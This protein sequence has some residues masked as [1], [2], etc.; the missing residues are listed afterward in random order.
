MNSRRIREATRPI[1][2]GHR[3]HVGRHD[4]EARDDVPAL[5]AERPDEVPPGEDTAARTR[6]EERDRLAVE[7]AGADNP[8]ERILHDAGDRARILGRGDEHSVCSS[9]LGT[10]AQHRLTRVVSVIGV[11]RGNRREAF[12]RAHFD[13]ARRQRHTGNVERSPVRRSPLKTAADEEDSNHQGRIC[14]DFPRSNTLGMG[15]PGAASPLRRALA[16]HRAPGVWK[17][18]ARGRRSALPVA[19]RS[20]PGWRFA[21]SGRSTQVEVDT[22]TARSVPG[23]ALCI[24]GA[25]RPT[26]VEVREPGSVV[27]GRR[28]PP[29]PGSVVARHPNLGRSSRPPSAP[30]QPGSVV[31]PPPVDP[32]RLRFA[33]PGFAYSGPVDPPRLR[34]AP[35]LRGPL[36]VRV[37]G[38]QG[39]RPD[40][41]GRRLRPRL[42]AEAGGA[43]GG[44]ARHPEQDQGGEVPGAAVRRGRLIRH[45][46]IAAASAEPPYAELGCFQTRLVSDRDAT[47]AEGLPGEGGAWSQSAK[48]CP[49]TLHARAFASPG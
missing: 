19:A 15:R 28:A 49:A 4:A 5:P 39:R 20:V 18:E 8:V 40:H 44:A 31:A 45:A 10:P 30:P 35:Q 38:V 27:A 47:S 1:G 22:S 24:F 25:G 26:Q 23:V 17:E 13:A 32:P 16:G 46:S 6:A 41:P 29:Q 48:A 14:E 36:P 7:L 37:L 33:G 34:F 3:L 43:P 12:E 21:Y 42:P 2:V 11:H 9:D